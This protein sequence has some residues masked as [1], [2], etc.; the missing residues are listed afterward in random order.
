MFKLRLVVET[1]PKQNHKSKIGSD[2]IFGPK[3]QT[4]LGHFRFKFFVPIRV[5]LHSEFS[6]QFFFLVGDNFRKLS[7]MCSSFNSPEGTWKIFLSR[8]II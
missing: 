8:G 4:D 5:G 3:K 7:I 6:L 2:H 1:M